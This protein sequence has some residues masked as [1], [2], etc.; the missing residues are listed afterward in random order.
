MDILNSSP[1]IALFPPGGTHP[2]SASHKHKASKVLTTQAPPLFLGAIKDDLGCGHGAD[3]VMIFCHLR[4][5]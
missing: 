4:L 5:D 1:H 2:L 3:I